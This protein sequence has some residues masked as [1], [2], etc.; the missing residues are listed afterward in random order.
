MI[1]IYSEKRNGV[2]FT[3]AVHDRKLVACS[4]SENKHESEQSIRKMIPKKQQ[5]EVG[6]DD[7]ESQLMFRRVY[8]AYSGDTKETG[9]IDFLENVSAFRRRVY[10]QLRRI[11]RGR[12]TTY[13]AI[14]KKLGSRRYSRAVGTAVATNPIS[15]IVPCHRVV[16][17]SFKVGNYGVPGQHPTEG[18]PVKRALLEREGVRFVRDKVSNDCIWSPA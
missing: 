11:P 7:L 18:G 15:I 9:S 16:P 3:I 14:A 4:F 13:G 12:V 1:R 8:G 10:V 2:W 5:V 17:S 6:R